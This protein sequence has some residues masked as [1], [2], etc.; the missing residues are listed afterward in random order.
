MDLETATMGMWLF[1]A[2]QG[3]PLPPDKYKILYDKG[4]IL[5]GT[6]T[7]DGHAAIKLFWDL[8]K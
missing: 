8:C 6:V 2:K 5:N 3:N 7:E 1:V 4:L